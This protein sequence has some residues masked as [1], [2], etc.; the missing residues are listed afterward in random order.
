MRRSR[1]G[2]LGCDVDAET[3]PVQRETSREKRAR[4]RG[5]W[6]HTKD[7]F[8]RHARQVLATKAVKEGRDELTLAG[9]DLL[10]ARKEAVNP[11]RKSVK[12]LLRGIWKKRAEAKK[13]GAAP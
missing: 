5:T 10:E 6:T 11:R 4:L 8:N 9:C 7:G 2:K 3:K 1:S 12:Y 13:K